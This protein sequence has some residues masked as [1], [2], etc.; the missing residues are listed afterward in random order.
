VKRL[1]TI[2]VAV[3]ATGVLCY[4]LF[5]RF[6]EI[7]RNVAVR[8]SIAYW[9]AG[10]LLLQGTDPYDHERVLVLERHQGYSEERPLVLRTP[11]WSLFMMV[12]LGLLSPFGAWVAWVAC[13]IGSLWVAMR[14]C[15]EL[16]GQG[17]PRDLFSLLGYTFAP[18]PA[19]LVSGQM[20]LVLLLGVALFFLWQK[21]RPFL[22]GIVLILP[23]AKPHLLLLF[24]LV[25]LT[26]VLL[27]KKHAIALGFLCSLGSAV[28]LSLLLDAHVFENYRGMLRLASIAHE[29]IPA[30][31][32]VIRLLFFRQHFW[33][34]FVPLGVGAVWC[35]RFLFKNF[36][37]WDWTEHGPALMVVSVLTTP[38]SWLAD[39][40]VLLPAV[41]QAAAFVY[42]SRAILTLRTKLWLG[43]FAFL[44]FL[45]LLILRSKIPFATG[46]YFWSSLVWF[47]WYFFALRLRKQA[48]SDG[49]P[50]VLVAKEDRAAAI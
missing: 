22:A 27:R 48:Q 25:L 9:S 29:F 50:N 7:R 26:W 10:R 31:S 21:N 43:L 20:G 34:Q 24:W 41:L 47:S 13:S 2:T 40:S 28:L 8:D 39:E 42:G 17:V 44:D 45:L 30:L 18:I 1:L 46:I 6:P 33:A 11:P 35:F 5:V 49:E 4:L 36:R 23:F 12:P 16:Y 15:R 38:Y 19:C 14:T 32:G 37:V 3:L